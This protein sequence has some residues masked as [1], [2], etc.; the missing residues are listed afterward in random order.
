MQE[1][2]FEVAYETGKLGEVTYSF[3]DTKKEFP[4][5]SVTKLFTTYLTLIQVNKNLLTLEDRLLPNNATVADLLAH[6][7]GLAF[8][9]YEFIHNLREYRQYSNIGMEIIGEYLTDITGIE[10]EELLIK[11]IVEPLDLDCFVF[12]D[13]KKPSKDGW[14]TLKDLRKFAQELLNPTLIPRKL[15][16]KACTQYLFLPGI[17]LNTMLEIDDHAWGLGFELK[18]SKTNHWMGNL[19][20]KRSFGHFGSAGSY[21]FIDLDKQTYNIFLGEKKY[22]IEHRQKWNKL[23]DELSAK[24]N[25]SNEN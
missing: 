14:A 7:S 21:L 24:H 10:Y 15:L 22:N 1:F 17:Y 8:D 4:L 13:E 6:T 16:E 5:A 9:K 25:I 11:E 23:N 19:S 12:K 18:G 2:S 3:G 20:S